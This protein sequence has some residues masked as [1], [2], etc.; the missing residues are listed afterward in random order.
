MALH[1]HSDGP[2]QRG[3][4][5]VQYGGVEETGNRR[6]P[7]S[8]LDVGIAAIDAGRA[9][10][11]G[12]HHAIGIALLEIAPRHDG[13]RDHVQA[14]AGVRP[15]QALTADLLPQRLGDVVPHHQVAVA[16][17]ARS[18]ESQ[19]LAVHHRVEHQGAVAQRAVGDQHRA[20]VDLVVD[21]LM[22]DEHGQRIEAGR[23]P[24]YQQKAWFWV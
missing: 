1:R 19:A 7:G 21:D 23:I 8:V 14:V 11:R 16:E 12:Q 4:A 18:A 3:I 10:R 22:D 2:L 15:H 13:R 17:Q 9:T 20:A 6:R 24:Q 5:V